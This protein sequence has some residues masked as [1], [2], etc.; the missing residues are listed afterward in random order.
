M[1]IEVEAFVAAIPDPVRRADTTTLM[2]LIGALNLGAPTLWGEHTIGYGNS[3]DGSSF[4]LGLCVRKREWVIFLPA[5]NATA[6]AARLQLG[7]HKVDGKR[8]YIKRLSDIDTGVLATLLS[9]T[10]DESRR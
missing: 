10:L 5:L 6:D 7:K 8:L 9:V 3:K 2:A 1:T 4:L